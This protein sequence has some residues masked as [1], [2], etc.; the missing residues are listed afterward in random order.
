MFYVLLY[1]CSP[2]F[3]QFSFTIPSF[4]HFLFLYFTIPPLSPIV[5]PSIFHNPFPLI[6]PP[7]SPNHTLLL[8]IPSLPL[9]LTVSKT[10]V[11]T[12][13]T[14]YHRL[15]WTSPISPPPSLCTQAFFFSLHVIPP[16]VELLFSLSLSLSLSL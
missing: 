6:P 10:S 13:F 12:K 9:L 4:S 1:H 15:L 14:G 8:I 3:L 7:S 11:A 2:F 5:T 16:H